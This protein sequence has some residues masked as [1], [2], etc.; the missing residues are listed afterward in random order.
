MSDVQCETSAASSLRAGR[1][2][3]RLRA[4]RPAPCFGSVEDRLSLVVVQDPYH[5]P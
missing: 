4:M 5:F 1:F 2:F 3:S